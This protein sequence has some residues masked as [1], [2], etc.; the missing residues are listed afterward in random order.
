MADFNVDLSAPHASGAKPIA[1]VHD[2]RTEFANPWIGFGLGVA[3]ALVKNQGEQAKK[4]QEAREAAIITNFTKDQTS[5]NDALMQGVPISQV[6]ARAMAN[7]SKYS[8]A[9]P[10]LVDKFSKT[11]KSLF[12][13]SQLGTAQ[14]DVQ[15][16]RDARKSEINDAVKTG[17][18]LTEDMPQPVVEKILH[19]HRVQKATEAQFDRIVKQNTEARTQA[20]YD[21]GIGKAKLQKESIMGLAQ[22]G[23]TQLPATYDSAMHIVDQA[24]KTGNVA[25]VEQELDRLLMPKF[26]AIT[27][28]GSN[29]DASLVNPY[30]KMFEE[31]KT[32]AMNKATGK[33]VGD[34]SDNALKELKN[35]MELT[36]LSSPE[37]KAVYS[38]SKLFG[39][40]IPPT[41]LETNQVGKDMIGKLALT[42]AA[43]S[44]TIVGTGKLEGA[45]YDLIKGNVAQVE[46]G[47]AADVEGVKTQASNLANNVL[48][49]IGQSAS[50]GISTKDLTAGY[51]FIASTDFQKLV[52]YGKIDKE[53]MASANRV[54]SMVYGKEIS[55]DIEKKLSAPFRSK[56]GATV[57]EHADLVNF[58]WNGS[59]IVAQQVEMKDKKARLD[60]M[61]SGARDVF[62]RD[63][64]KSTEAIN[65][66]VKAG[67]H[68]EG[69][70]NYE[71][72]WEKNKSNI[73]PNIYPPENVKPNSVH[74]I[75]GKK[76]KYTGGTPWRRAQYWQEVSGSE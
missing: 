30:R 15:M 69:H 27:A 48:H 12:E 51:N 50:K 63:M 68:M 14:S 56:D 33:L 60:F 25:N 1:P 17:Y 2:A 44:P 8:A 29:V 18:Y 67:A 23:D 11:N 20:N 13:H 19:A 53:A 52:A 47:K 54:F 38:A 43:N 40:V 3:E 46:S 58:N 74:E 32:V 21:E 34:A 41:F 66:L 71:Q 28:L 10:T 45:A 59:S 6:N 73:L 70:T 65:K 75:Q 72:Y 9:F 37:N 5:L 16:F 76:F 49:Q 55:Q 26:Q 31:I 39:G 61:E 36:T 64:Q 35:R 62:V 24:M 7:F 22:I 42:F 57:I 4:D